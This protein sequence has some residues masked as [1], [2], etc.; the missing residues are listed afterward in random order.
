MCISHDHCKT[1][2]SLQ[3]GVRFMLKT[4]LPPSGTMKLQSKT[5]IRHPYIPIRLTKGEKENFQVLL[6]SNAVMSWEPR[7]QNQTLHFAVQS[8]HSDD[9]ISS[10]AN[11]TGRG[12]LATRKETLTH[13]ASHPHHTQAALINNCK[14]KNPQPTFYGYTKYLRRQSSWWTVRYQQLWRQSV[15]T[16]VLIP[17]TSAQG[18]NRLAG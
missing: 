13:T 9:V 2:S 3:S 10:D 7:G 18:C 8:S 17:Q 11:S 14:G 16:K 1:T 4:S 12:R 15:R 5:G 6:T